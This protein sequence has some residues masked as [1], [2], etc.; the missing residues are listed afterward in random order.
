MVD[1][2]AY[3]SADRE[4]GWDLFCTSLMSVLSLGIQ[5]IGRDFTLSSLCLPFPL[6]LKLAHHHH[7]SVSL[8]IKMY[9]MS[10]ILVS[11]LC[12]TNAFLYNTFAFIMEA[13]TFS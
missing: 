5:G 6:D 4:E 11:Q 13:T 3:C 2:G 1:S 10:L 7:H 9:M 12:M 8:F